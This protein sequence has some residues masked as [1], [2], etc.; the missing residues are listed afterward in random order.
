MTDAN[1][2][3]HHFKRTTHVRRRHVLR[4]IRIIRERRP[5]ICVRPKIRDEIFEDAADLGGKDFSARFGQYNGW[6]VS[7]LP[8]LR[9][10]FCPRLGFSRVSETDAPDRLHLLS[11]RIKGSPLPT[12][13]YN[14]R[15]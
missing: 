9:A 5:V 7:R 1:S 10:I 12:A 13:I 15:T 3:N 8:A 14:P 6:L 4:E 2:P 11:R